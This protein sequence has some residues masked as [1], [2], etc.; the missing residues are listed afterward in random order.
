MSSYPIWLNVTN[1]NYKTTKSFGYK[2]TGIINYYVGT[3]GKNSNH[4]LES[5]VKKREIK[6]KGKDCV[7]FSYSINGVVLI[8]Q[9][10]SYENKKLKLI[11]TIDKTKKIKSIII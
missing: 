2:N 4:L 3:S 9:I 5:I 10:Y 6:Y 1:C 11:K 7:L 8:I